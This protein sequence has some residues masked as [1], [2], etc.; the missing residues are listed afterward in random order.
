MSRIRQSTSWQSTSQKTNSTEP[1][2]SPPQDCSSE[3]EFESSSDDPPG[4][5]HVGSNDPNSTYSDPKSPPV[6]DALDLQRV[7]EGLR[8][9]QTFFVPIHYEQNYNYPLIV[10]LHNDGFNENQLSQVMPHIS[11]RNYLAT[12]VRATR[13]ID[14]L[15]HSF[16]WRDSE[17][18]LD[19]A[20]EKVL[21][22]IA[23]VKDRYS[24]HNDRIVLAGYQTGASVALQLALRD[25]SQFAGVVSMGGRMPIGKRMLGKFS[26]IRD[27]G[28]KMLW[29]NAI[30]G[31][32]YD[33][34]DLREDIRQIMM[35]NCEVEIRNYRAE[36]LLYADVFSDVNRWV[37][38]RIVLDQPLGKADYCETSPV[39]FSDN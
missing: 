25:P 35:L 6:F 19:V 22:A 21:T 3:L 28:L 26:E 36:D 27:A 4:F 17:A 24:V 23:E 39:A 14:S 20:Y 15:G 2:T 29:Q 1:N 7:P 38:N 37:M 18:A 5:E 30:E 31:P 34:S 33:D 8:W 13:A 11:T 16:E 9:P 32:E 12:G 10:W